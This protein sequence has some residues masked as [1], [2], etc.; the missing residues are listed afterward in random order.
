MRRSNRRTSQPYGRRKADRWK[1]ML[2]VAIVGMCLVLIICAGLSIV[3][4]RQQDNLKAQQARSTGAIRGACE[5][6]QIARDD[7]N[8]QA[9]TIYQVILLSSGGGRDMRQ[10]R[11]ERISVLLAKVDPDTRRLI[12]FLLQRGDQ[13]AAIYPK[14]LEQTK[15]LPPTSCREAVEHPESY[16]PPKPIP[17][18]RVAACYDPKTNPRPARPCLKAQKPPLPTP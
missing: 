18:R 6:L 12:M 13:A 9:W 11:A 16:R 8:T 5:R 17:F 1:G 10:G 14:V 3:T 15:F 2:P 4:F 7:L